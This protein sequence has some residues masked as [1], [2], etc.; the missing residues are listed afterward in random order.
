MA[1]GA[2]RRARGRFAAPLPA[3]ARAAV[4]RPDGGE[5]GHRVS[6]CLERESQARARLEAALPKLAAGLP[7]CLRT[8]RR[9]KATYRRFC[10]AANTGDAELISK[11]FECAG[12]PLL[13]GLRHEH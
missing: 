3:L 10:D 5:D 4:R 6:R 13:R 2:R 12:R 9:S 7:R 8:K 1:T 11:T